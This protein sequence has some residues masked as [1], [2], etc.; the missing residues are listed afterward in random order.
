MKRFVYKAKEQ[1]SGKIIKGTIQ[2]ETERVAGKLLLDR[3]YIPESLREEGKSFGDKLNRVTSKDR[4]TFTRQFATLV[5]AGLPIAQSLRTVS[6]QTQNK[7]MKA[8]VEEILAEIE[9]GH[10]LGDAFAKHPEVF[11]NVYLSL[12]RAGEVSG[13]L[14]ESLK[15]IAMQEEKDAKM[16]SS[17]KGAMVMPVITLFVIFVV[18]LY[19]MLEVVPQVEG[20]YADLGEELPA[21]TLA[22]VAIKDFIINFWWLAILILAGL[23]AGF[24]Q[25]RKTEPGIR[26]MAKLK[27]N[28]PMFNGLFRMLYM[29]RLAR[30]SQILLSTGVSVLDTLQIAGESM[31]NVVVNDEVIDAMD[32]VQS[33]KAM[34]DALKDHDYILPLVY[35][36]AAI[37][38]QSGKMDEMLGKAAQVFEDDLDEK[39]AAISSAIEPVMMILLAIMAG[40]LVGGI[41]FP[42]YAL[43]NTI[44]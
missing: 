32:K 34:S 21:L 31:N 42:I 33:G 39:V 8:I 4:I 13:T 15:R 28:V 20:L 38:E 25:Y 7:A 11:S 29:A 16:M 41:L 22:F 40:G 36:M 30:I 18:F 10:S 14:D 26:A 17:I 23:V 19:M 2:A 12:V 44:A 24:L 37:G 35:Q 9:A 5:G 43:V 6:E 27:L 3:G 1:S